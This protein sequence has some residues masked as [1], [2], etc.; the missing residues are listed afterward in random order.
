MLVD[1]VEIGFFGS[2]RQIAPIDH[3][4]DV[5]IDETSESNCLAHW[6]AIVDFQSKTF[7]RASGIRLGR[8]IF[9]RPQSYRGPR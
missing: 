7:G 5:A 3:F 8:I 2:V 1:A 6:Q 4:A 9:D